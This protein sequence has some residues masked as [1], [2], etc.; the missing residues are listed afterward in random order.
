MTKIK[1]TNNV[2]ISDPCYDNDVLCKTK[3]TDVVPGKYN[4]FVGKEESDY[5]MRIKSLRVIH[6]NFSGTEWE[7]HSEI[8]VDSG[9]AGIFCETGYRNDDTIVESIVIPK[10]NFDLP[11]RDGEGDVWYRKMCNFT[12][13]EDQSGVYDTGVVTSSGMGDG[14]YPLHIMRDK[15]GYIVGMRI[16]YMFDEK[17]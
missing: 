5:G 4:V 13:S 14:L 2:R 7:E 16:T 3:L 6:E 15:N 10:S 9:Q 12:L 17:T 1:L 11:G 8:A